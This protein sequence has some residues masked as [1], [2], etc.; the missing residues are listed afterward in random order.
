MLLMELLMTQ[1]RRSLALD[2]ALKRTLAIFKEDFKDRVSMGYHS[3]FQGC[4]HLIESRSKHLDMTHG[5]LSTHLLPLLPLLTL[6]KGSFPK[7]VEDQQS[8]LEKR[9][10]DTFRPISYKSVQGKALSCTSP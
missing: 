5:A 4:V 7:D 3:L 1:E 2:I 8:L 9:L 6:E 10:V